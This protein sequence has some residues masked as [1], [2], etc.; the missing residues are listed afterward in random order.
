MSMCPFLGNGSSTHQ[1]RIELA[2]GC[3]ERSHDF[4]RLITLDYIDRGGFAGSIFKN[5]PG[6]LRVWSR[7]RHGHGESRSCSREEG[8]AAEGEE[9]YGENFFHFGSALYSAILGPDKR[10]FSKNSIIFRN[11]L[12]PCCV[13]NAR[14]F[15]FL[16]GS[17]IIKDS[18]FGLF[19]SRQPSPDGPW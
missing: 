6:R 18:S 8:G 9:G 5:E 19:T 17:Q 15:R 3:R 14:Q 10:F 4:S 11:R 12:A 2:I 1:F 7:R 13:H 16:S